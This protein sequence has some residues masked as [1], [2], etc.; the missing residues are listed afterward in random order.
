MEWRGGRHLLLNGLLLAERLR[1]VRARLLVCLIDLHGAA[2]A[3]STVHRGRDVHTNVSPPGT[4]C[5]AG[6]LRFATSGADSV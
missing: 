2:C 3:M 5:V 4:V 6:A 1:K